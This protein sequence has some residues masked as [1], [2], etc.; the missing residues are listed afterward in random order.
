[1]RVTG[2]RMEKILLEKVSLE[3]AP[4]EKDRLEKLI[5]GFPALWREC[6][7]SGAE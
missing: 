6:G 4:L 5:P 1:M 3:R 2:V 7:S